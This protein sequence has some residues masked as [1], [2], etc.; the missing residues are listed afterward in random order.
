[1]VGVT[2]DY[3]GNP[4]KWF[5]HGANGTECALRLEWKESSLVGITDE[6]TNKKYEYTYNADGLR[7]GKTVDG[8]RHEY[9]LSGSKILAETRESG[10]TKKLI[11]YYY[12]DTGVIGFN[13]DG[14]D[15]YFVKSMQG[16]VEKIYSASGELKAEYSYDSWGKCTI[17]RSVSGIAEAN[18]F[19]YRGY[20]FDSESGL[21]YLNS[22][23]YDPIIGRF[24][25]PDSLDN[26]DPSAIGGLNLYA[27][28]GNNPIMYV[29]PEGKFLGLAIAN[30][31]LGIITQLI[32]SVVLYIGF[33]IAALFNKDIR[34]DMNAIHW[35]PFNT[36]EAAALGSKKV[37]FYKGMPIIRFNGDR[38]GTF[39]VSF[40]GREGVDETVLKHERG[41]AWHAM[42]IGPIAYG[43]TVAIMSSFELGPY[44]HYYDSP[45]ENIADILGGTSHDCQ[46]PET[47]ARAWRFFF[48]SI[49]AF[50]A[51]YAYI[52]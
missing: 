3:A 33:A 35:N 38:S 5:K 16:D 1:M 10:G 51:T 40:L 2:Y 32:V 22:R 6:T 9:Y 31:I 26:L 27:Y 15:Y 34:D 52:F 20:Y 25:S 24:I 13:L 50:W 39:Y 44:E 14:T 42:L 23:Y 19:R 11:K 47:N 4:R 17:K 43:L 28:C 46:T 7:T 48:T 49:F 37:S 41:H 8:V 30:L 29:D 12:D 18:A 45:W 21:Y 36:D